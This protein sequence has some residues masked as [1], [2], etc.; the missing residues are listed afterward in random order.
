MNLKTVRVFFISLA[1][2][3]LLFVLSANERIWNR[4][5]ETDIILFLPSLGDPPKNLLQ[6]KCLSCGQHS[7]KSSVWPDVAWIWKS[8]KNLETR[9]S[10]TRQCQNKL[11][12]V[13]VV[14]TTPPFT[15]CF[16][17]LIYIWFSPST[18]FNSVFHTIRQHIFNLPSNRWVVLF[19]L[20]KFAESCLQIPSTI[21]NE[22]YNYFI[23]QVD[24]WTFRRD[25]LTPN[26]CYMRK[27]Q[28]EEIRH[29]TRALDIIHLR[30]NKWT[31][32]L[33]NQSGL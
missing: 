28:T 10:P 19:T 9:S 23:D 21:N 31:S 29:H 12:N 7:P 18:L 11:Y 5:C 20:E 8:N 32:C 15:K 13:A 22:L 3:Q 25:L 16:N 2:N 6:S 1:R 4:V 33:V 26:Y 24:S 27:K 17:Q 14:W 30:R